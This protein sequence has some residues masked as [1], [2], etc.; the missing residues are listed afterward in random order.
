MKRIISIL[1][2]V[3]LLLPYGAALTETTD[4]I[5]VDEDTVVEEGVQEETQEEPAEAEDLHPDWVK[6]NYNYLEVGNPTVTD[7]KFFT[8]MWGNATS[9]IDVRTLLHGYNLVQWDGDM[10]MFRTNHSVVN[11]AVI[12]DNE[13]GDRT[14][15]LALYD[16]LKYSDGTPITAWDYAFSVLLMID[17]K[18]YELE[19]GQ[20]AKNAFFKGY[21]EYVSGEA[22]TLSG[23]HVVSDYMISF[24]VKHEY[25]P[26]FFELYRLGYYPYPIHVIAPGCKVYDDGEGIYIGN[27]DRAD[28]TPVFT[29]GLLQRTI[30][31][32]ETGYLTHP[33]VV[34]GP[35]TLAYYGP[36]DGYEMPE[37]ALIPN[38]EAVAPEAEEETEAP[39]NEGEPESETLGDLCGAE[40]DEEEAEA[41]EAE[42]APVELPEMRTWEPV[43]GLDNGAEMLAVFEINPYFKGDENGVVP[44]IPRILYRLGVDETMIDELENGQFALLNKVSRRDNIMDGLAMVGD[45]FT[46]SN[47]PRIGLTFMTFVPDVPALQEKN[48]RKAIAHCLD[49]DNVVL[50][51]VS[52]FGIPV[53][54]FYGMGQWMYQLTQ[55]TITYEPPMSEE[56]TA[57]E[58][59]AAEE[60]LARADALN[61][62]NLVHYDLDVEAAIALLE[63]NG[64]TLNEQGDPY[65][66][67]QGH[68]RYTMLDGEL[69]GLDF[70]MGYPYTNVTAEALKDLH[71]PNLLEAGIRVELV[72]M[73]M[74]DLHI[75]YDFRDSDEVQ[76]FYLGDNFNIEFDP[77]LW[78]LP[79]E[80]VEEGDTL[81]WAHARMY[82]L[83]EDMCRTEPQDVLTFVEKWIKFQEEFSDLLPMIPVYSNVYFD[84]FTKELH[85]YE[86]TNYVTWGLAIVP[87]T[88]SEWTA[89]DEA[90][91]NQAEEAGEGVEGL[92]EGEIILDE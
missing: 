9:D 58:E 82:E 7:G 6:Y 50:E 92:D 90:A 75:S 41:A 42:E 43:E 71:L 15:L 23:V 91:A 83:A 31:D 60:L 44:T 76:M 37:D 85:N 1:L 33:S 64:W 46:M 24:T 73:E 87:A 48:V 40:G 47:Y 68:V 89:E 4:D 62:D 72:P 57:E 78:F 21:E 54:G 2:A 13:E 81:A 79:G 56:P 55:G 26:Y 70:K 86:I 3:L 52:D 11:G 51:Y 32:P 20:P 27:E 36:R 25:L 10:G 61:L 77:T 17:Q 66:L 67:G 63:E 65:V 18:V 22:A 84:F 5:V 59:K 12:T 38:E 30:M 28:E 35:Y 49:K 88:F 14:Y 74:K 19:N 39:E 45:Q 80:G 69:T 16:D 53:D 34:S 8:G 29:A